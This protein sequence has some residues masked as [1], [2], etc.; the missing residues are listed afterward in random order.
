MSAID[1]ANCNTW[2]RGPSFLR[3][4]EDTWPTNKISDQPIGDD[5][6][7]RILTQKII[8]S[9]SEPRDH[10]TYLASAADVTFPVDPRHY[11]S[12]LKLKIIQAWVNRFTEYSRKR[13]AEKK[14][15]ELIADELKKAEIQLL[16]HT[17]FVNIQDE[18]NALSH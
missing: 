15:G 14:P 11:S 5:K 9:V 3:Q 10:H 13:S 6:M 16:K 7:K 18:W 4:T 2:W 8:Y 12:W 1:L 17:Q